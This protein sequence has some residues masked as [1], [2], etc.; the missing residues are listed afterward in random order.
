[1]K[2]SLAD[3]ALPHEAQQALE[4]LGQ[5]IRDARKARRMRQKDFAARCLLSVDRLRKLE[6]GEPTVGLGALA[7][8][9][10]VLD[11]TDQLGRVAA[12]DPMTRPHGHIDPSVHNLDF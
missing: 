12:L 6:Q 9:L 8:A 4:Q 10:F 1:M 3:S 2:N 7:Q 5:N 11:M